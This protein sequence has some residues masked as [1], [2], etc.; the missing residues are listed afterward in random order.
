M[1]QASARRLPDQHPPGALLRQ[2]ANRH[3]RPDKLHEI[4]I[5]KRQSCRSEWQCHSQLHRLG[6]QRID[7]RVGLRRQADTIPRGTMATCSHHDRLPRS[8]LATVALSGCCS[9][10]ANCGA[11]DRMVELRFSSSSR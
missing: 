9:Q 6:A 2:D 7:L 8:S 4:R 10:R 5:I 3:Q 1:G 11:E